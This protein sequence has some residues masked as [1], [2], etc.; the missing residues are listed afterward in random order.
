LRAAFLDIDPTLNVKVEDALA[1]CSRWFC[2]YYDSYTLPLR[3]WPSLWRRIERAQS[4]GESTGPGWLYRWGARPLFR[5][6]ARLQPQ[7]VVA[8]EVGVCEFVVMYKR[9]TRAPFALVGLELMDFN[10]AW[11]QPEVDLYPVV[12]PD[13]GVELEAAGAPRSKILMTGMPLDPRFSILPSRE[14]ARKKLGLERDLPVVLA[15]F[16]GSGFGKPREIA[17]ALRRIHTRFQAVFIAGKNQRLQS[18]LLRLT[19]DREAWQALA[20]VDNMH[21]WMAAADLVLSKPG[22]ATVMEAAAAGL[23]FLAFDPLPGNEERT[24]SWLEK[25]EV[26]VW[27]KSRSQLSATLERLLEYPDERAKL[28]ERSRSLSRPRAAYE[29]AQAILSRV[30]TTLRT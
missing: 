12:H 22:G 29:I 2:A 30:G 15:L 5:T 19:A 16:G 8:S 9:Q 17:E 23:P 7:A 10:R 13:L 4:Q 18:E 21:E 25:W 20:W 1:L 27:I 14:E 11:V 6:L 28:A 3:Y 26:G 24:C